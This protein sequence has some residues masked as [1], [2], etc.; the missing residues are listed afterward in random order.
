MVPSRAV[1]AIR[2]TLAVLASVLLF[3][4]LGY[5][6]IA[7][8]LR[9][10]LLNADY[11]YTEIDRAGPDRWVRDAVQE[12]MPGRLGFALLPAFDAAIQEQRP[13]LLEQVRRVADMI[14]AFL[15]DAERIH[16]VIDAAPVEESVTRHVEMTLANE[17]P[18]VFAD[19]P[20]REKAL[21]A[22]LIRQGIAM[23]FTR[24]RVITVDSDAMPDEAILRLAGLRRYI[25]MFVQYPLWVPVAAA[26]VLAVLLIVL[27]AP[28]MLGA[29]LLAFA[30]VLLATIAFGDRLT[31]LLPLPSLDSMPP[32]VS[33]YV[34]IFLARMLRTLTPVGLGCLGLGVVSLIAGMLIPSKGR[35]R[36]RSGLR[37]AR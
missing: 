18:E 15:R 10:T 20:P 24:L 1:D 37:P 26:S 27:R 28:A 35:R 30:A 3:A 6:S 31:G 14:P 11:L 4:A 25:R 36:R 16:I 9:N 5:G 12:Q 2:R 22:E 17:P 34:P 33:G 7:Y 21:T 19:L 29:T 8:Q 32:I 23:A 13:W